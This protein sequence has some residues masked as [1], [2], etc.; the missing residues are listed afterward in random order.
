MNDR[1]FVGQRLVALEDL[2]A[3]NLF[4]LLT[5]PNVEVSVEIGDL[6][7]LTQ[8]ARKELDRHDT[9]ELVPKPKH[10]DT[11]NIYR[12]T[13]SLVTQRVSPQQD[14]NHG[15]VACGHKFRSC[16]TM[17]L[18]RIPYIT[19]CLSICVDCQPLLEQVVTE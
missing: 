14:S 5:S 3:G 19:L 7:V 12:D 18:L 17:F 2:V 9:L 11:V 4:L 13:F 1:E 16:E 15:C 6:S 10:R 8:L